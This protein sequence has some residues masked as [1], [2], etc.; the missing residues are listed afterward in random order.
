MTSLVETKA[1]LTDAEYAVLGLLTLGE[2][3]GYDLSK[4]AQQNVD[5]ILA[6]AKSRIYAVLPRLLRRGY[7]S[8]QEV[9]QEDRP[10]KHVYGLTPEGRA[11]FESWLND[12]AEPVARDQLL[13]KLFFGREADAEALLEQVRDF[14]EA[15]LVE[16]EVLEGIHPEDPFRALTVACGVALA[17]ASIS[18]AEQAID[19]LGSG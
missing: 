17:R 6:P 16:L 12:T 2:S 7:V 3:S 8:R 10:D 11:A 1:A 5:L 13:L 9:A 18:W 4:Y 15:K 19:T 14:R